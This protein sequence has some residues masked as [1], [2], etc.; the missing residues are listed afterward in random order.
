LIR[1]EP[2]VSSPHLRQNAE[3]FLKAIASPAPDHVIATAAPL[4]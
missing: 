4:G 2:E 3:H 1:G